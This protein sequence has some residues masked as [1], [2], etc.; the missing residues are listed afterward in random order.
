M[1]FKKGVFFFHRD[2]FFS[3]DKE[4]VPFPFDSRMCQFRQLQLQMKVAK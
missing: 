1:D 2:S 4:S 3:A